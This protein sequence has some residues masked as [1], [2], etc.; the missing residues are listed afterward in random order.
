MQKTTNDIAIFLF[1]VSFLI[2]AMVAFIVIM[3]YAY[4]KKQF[5][6]FQNLEQ[7][8]LDH[9]KNLMA[10]QLEIQEQTFQNISRE[11]HDNISLSLTL[12]KLQLNTLNLGDKDQAETKLLKSVELISKSINELSD[13]SKGLNADIIKQ[14]G[15][16]KALEDETQRI[17]QAS[18]FS[19]EIHITGNPIYM[20]AQK[21]L[22]IFRTIQEAFNNIIKHAGASQIQLRLHYN[23]TMLYIEVCDNGNGF[24]PNLASEKNKAG[25]KN[26]KTRIKMLGGTMNIN[27]RPGQGSNLSFTIPFE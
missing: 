26:M 13:I 7:I 17:R 3:L 10:T 18:I 5:L 19:I 8:K 23:K 16:I 15:L 22:I 12:A 4:R 9:E 14:Q 25:L 2:I 1:I 20:D 24:D 6:F 11:I 27:S 21:E